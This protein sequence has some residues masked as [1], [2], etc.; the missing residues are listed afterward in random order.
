LKKDPKYTQFWKLSLYRPSF[1]LFMRILK[2]VELISGT[3]CI[4]L[5]V[6]TISSF[7]NGQI[8]SHFLSSAVECLLVC[9]SKRKKYISFL[10]GSKKLPQSSF[11]W[12]I[13]RILRR[14]LSGWKSNEQVRKWR[15]E[16]GKE[17]EK[18]SVRVRVRVRVRECVWE[19]ECVCE[20]ERE[21][22]GRPKQK[23][24]KL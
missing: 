8:L 2:T 16:K 10:R 19:R 21:I 1:L 23:K 5:R 3:S 4:L 17:R 18:E 9:W 15:W 20:R 6:R 13:K 11:R 24:K 12:E 14:C 7:S 22:R